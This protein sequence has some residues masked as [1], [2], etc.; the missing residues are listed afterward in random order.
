MCS[1]VSSV[2]AAW[3]WSDM[4]LTSR[5]G[6]IT[7]QSCV[8]SHHQLVCM[9]ASHVV[10]SWPHYHFGP[11]H[12]T[13]SSSEKLREAFPEKQRMLGR[14][15]PASHRPCVDS[16]NFARKAWPQMAWS[17]YLCER[18]VD[19]FFSVCGAGKVLCSYA[20][21]LHDLC[22][23][24]APARCVSV[25]LHRLLL[26]SSACDCLRRPKWTGVHDVCKGKK[27]SVMPGDDVLENRSYFCFLRT[28]T[29][30]LDPFFTKKCTSQ[31]HMARVLAIYVEKRSD[32]SQAA[33][34]GRET[35]TKSCTSG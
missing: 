11:K 29:Q 22:L 8:S 19:L 12:F 3:L 27:T 10:A 33:M 18:R 24:L 9:M 23:A 34:G 20:C 4:N 31:K 6:D 15:W 25:S 16:Q 7:V 2:D 21:V 35:H 28:D 32:A 5:L 30:A 13:K 1:S 14:V 17:V 26:P